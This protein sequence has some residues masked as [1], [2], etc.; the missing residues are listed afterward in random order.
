[1][2]RPTVP[3]AD[4]RQMQARAPG[5]TDWADCSYPAWF[6]AHLDGRLVVAGISESHLA[7][8][9]GDGFLTVG[10]WGMRSDNKRWWSAEDTITAERTQLLAAALIPP[11]QGL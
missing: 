10:F 5:R 2:D 1:M 7:C 4:F 11:S 8:H 9:P 3:D 6:K